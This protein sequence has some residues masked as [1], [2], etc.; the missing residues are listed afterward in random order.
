[1]VDPRQKAIPLMA[2]LKQLAKATDTPFYAPGHKRG[3]GVSPQL[4]Q[5]LGLDV[6]QGDLPELPALDNLFAS[7]GVI[8]AAQALAADLWGAERTWFSV[9][10]ST[11]GL[12]A[13]IL[14]TCGEGDKILLPR[15]A[16][17]AAIAGIIHAGAMPIFLT[18]AAD[19][20]WDLAF[21]ITP[22]TLTQA[23]NNH[24]DAKALL[25]LH[26]TY[27]GV[28][29]H[30]AELIALSHQAGIPVIVDEAHGAHFAFHEQLPPPALALGADLTIQSTHK[31]LGALSQAAMIHQQKA[32]ERI[33]PQR[34]SQALQL[35]QST[36][37]N[38]LLLAS[39]D[40]ARH[41]MANDGKT[42]LDAIVQH[43]LKCRAQ[44]GEIPGLKLLTT[45]SA[46]PGF[47]ALDPTRITLDATAWGFSGFALDDLL[48]E[49]F[50]LT[51]ELPTLRQL[52][53]I[54]S[55]GNT[56]QDLDHLVQVMRNVAQS[57]QDTVP[58][59]L[60]LPPL[61]PSRFALTPRHAT[62]APQR[63]LPVE[64]AI[65]NVSADLLCPYP[66][67]IPVL[68]PGEIITPAAIAYLE[69]VLA[70]GGT[71]SGLADHSLKTLRV[72]DSPCVPR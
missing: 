35:I 61:P 70:L 63:T 19:P 34:I 25:L 2:R 69:T 31:L 54:V 39:L 62:F 12:I 51:A 17:Q 67:G 6:F 24:P 27:H 71:V 15:N 23:L 42:Q 68:V 38:Y 72:V 33:D 13:A 1:M 46:Q 18:P 41:Q 29:G 37:P 40:A 20:D 60:S 52:S 48:R 16:H 59:S 7:T 43:T 56:P 36:S 21:S 30:L 9:N 66:P 44:L 3:Q 22:E 50:H 5:W 11:A 4:S 58:Y 53:F 49:Q 57:R 28:V 64:A 10:G 65:A 45:A 55:L 8:A 14:A 32:A 26:P 47:S